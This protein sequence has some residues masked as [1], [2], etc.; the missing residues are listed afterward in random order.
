M[1]KQKHICGPA[2]EIRSRD[3]FSA[4]VED[5]LIEREHMPNEH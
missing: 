3:E 1:T 5:T 2:R 4:G